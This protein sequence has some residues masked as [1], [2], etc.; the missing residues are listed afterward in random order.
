M[1]DFQTFINQE[2]DRLT[3]KR[4]ELEA[5]VADL[6]TA[7]GGIDRELHAITVYEQARTG[8]ANGKAT[9]PARGSRRDAVLAIIKDHKGIEPKGIIEKLGGAPSGAIH[10][11]LG[12]LKK[13][14]KITATDGKYALA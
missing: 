6:Q 1:S 10:N 4:S 2:R 9:K 5:Q 8:K 14:G 12:T 3:K 7:I 13:E 11:L